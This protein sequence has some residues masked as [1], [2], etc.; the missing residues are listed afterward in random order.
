MTST[1]ASESD[2]PGTAEKLPGM[3]DGVDRMPSEEVMR[4]DGR[5]NQQNGLWQFC[6]R[7]DYIPPRCRWDLEN[8]PQF[9]W[10]LCLLFACVS[11]IR[12][13]L[14]AMSGFCVPPLS[15]SDLATRC[16]S[17]VLITQGRCF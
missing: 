17:Q 4:Q 12:G 1:E 10:G 16:C 7:L 8:P 3:E 14:H 2:I 9:N 6:K 15:M 11:P 13:S 5:S